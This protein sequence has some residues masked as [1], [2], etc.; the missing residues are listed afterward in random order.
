MCLEYTIQNTGVT[1]NLKTTIYRIGRATVN[2]SA[3]FAIAPVP[4]DTDPFGLC[5]HRA[6]R[7]TKIYGPGKNSGQQMPIR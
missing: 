6:G 2:H 1:D 3:Q 4:L 7:I 5:Q